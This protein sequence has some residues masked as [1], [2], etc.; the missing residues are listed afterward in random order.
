MFSQQQLDR[1]NVQLQQVDEDTTHERST[2]RH[3]KNEMKVPII[4]GPVKLLLFTYKVEVSTVLHLKR[5]NYQ[6]MK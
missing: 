2:P 1:L 6:Y 4:N 5:Q 3:L